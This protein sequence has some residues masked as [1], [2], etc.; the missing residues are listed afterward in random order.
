M[1]L[2]AIRYVTQSSRL[3]SY[4]RVET[5]NQPVIYKGRTS[6]EILGTDEIKVMHEK[7]TS[8]KSYLRSV[9]PRY[10]GEKVKK[11]L[12]SDSPVG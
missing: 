5:N 10:R 2:A 7:D 3:P 4:R 11:A 9:F 6:F 8:L 12:E 1:N